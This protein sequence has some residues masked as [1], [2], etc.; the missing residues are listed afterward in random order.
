[1]KSEKNPGKISKI[2]NDVMPWNLKGDSLF[3][4]NDSWGIETRYVVSSH[5][6][7]NNEIFRRQGLKLCKSK[8]FHFEES[9]GNLPLFWDLLLS[10]IHFSHLEVDY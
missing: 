4:R 9:P 2:L 10:E 5:L 6:P 3:W 7:V 8:R 1:M